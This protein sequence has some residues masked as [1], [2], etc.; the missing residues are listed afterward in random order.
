MIVAACGPVL[1]RG[2]GAPKP[3]DT[4]PTAAPST[5]A[6]ADSSPKPAAAPSD[7]AAKA[8]SAARTKPDSAAGKADSVAAAKG[9][10][11]KKR[12]AQQQSRPCTLDFSESPPES[13]VLALKQGPTAVYHTFIGGGVAARCQGEPALLR[14]DSAEHY[15]STGILYL[16][17]NVRYDEPTK[18][19]FTSRRATYYTAEERLIADSGVTATQLKTGSQMYGMQLEYLR[20]VPGKRAAS[21]LVA[22]NRPTVR[23]EEKDKGDKAGPPVI[24]T[25]NT[26]VDDA[27]SLLYAVGDVDINRAEINARSDSGAFDKGTS[28]SRLIR[29]ASIVSR[30]Q[31]QPYR[32]SSDTIDLF[33]K[34]R[35]LERVLAS[36]NGRVTNKD[37]LLIGERI[38]MRLVE[39]KLERASAWGAKR[40][41]ATTP[42]QEVESDSL[43]IEMPGQR[44]REIH[45]I[46]RATATGVPDTVRIRTTERDVMRGDTILAKFDSV[47]TPGDTTNRPKIR[48]VFA[49]GNATSLYHVATSRG[50]AGP[51]ALNYVRGVTITVAFDSGQVRVVNVDST[52]NGVY[53]EPIDSAAVDSLR[54]DSARA[55]S[56]TRRPPSGGPPPRRPPGVS[57]PHEPA[58]P[59]PDVPMTSLAIP[60]GAAP[61]RALRRR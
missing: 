36:S 18:L 47:V 8:D 20:E 54:P 31:K 56:A 59:S 41:K 42:E 19:A 43:Y 38:D 61:A 16:I 9:A 35:A 27:D 48:E 21:R 2:R 10:P 13:R 28:R 29:N 30:D 15:E 50:R 51:P 22:P 23:L 12:V 25:A 52:A 55:D 7:S 58:L 17:G 26:I 24:L 57:E 37:I 46:G 5:P 44:V 49:V 14:A 34:D 53:L 3:A 60:S 4:P 11:P 45:A 40:A 1:R 6:P 32:L 39:S 33:N